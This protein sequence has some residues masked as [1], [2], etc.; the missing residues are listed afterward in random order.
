MALDP[1]EQH[2]ISAA[3]PNVVKSMQTEMS[4]DGTLEHRTI[5]HTRGASTEPQNENRSPR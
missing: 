5:V 3:N 2:E 4:W 1:Y